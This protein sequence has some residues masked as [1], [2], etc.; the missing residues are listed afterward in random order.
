MYDTLGSLA[1]KHPLMPFPE[2]GLYGIPVVVCTAT[3]G[4]SEEL[5]SACPSGFS[6]NGLSRKSAVRLSEVLFTDPLI[7]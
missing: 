6:G 7:G 3:A 2:K 4:P 1:E 5:P